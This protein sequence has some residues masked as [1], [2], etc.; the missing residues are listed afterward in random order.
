MK[1]ETIMQPKS[2]TFG[3]YNFS[4]WQI[5]CLVN[6]VDK[7]QPA[8]ST[9]IRWLTA[10]LNEFR[11]HFNLSKDGNLEIE[12]PINE[13]ER[14]H[15]G[16]RVLNEIKKL[17]NQNVYYTYTDEKGEV[18]HRTCHLIQTMDLSDEGDKVIL[19]I[20]VAAL[21]WLIYYGQGVGGTLYD[22][23]SVLAI[24][25]CYAKRVFQ[26][27]SSYL[28]P[29]SWEVSIKKL[30][31]ELS[32][33]NYTVRDFERFVLTPAKKELANNLESRLMFKYCLV[34]KGE[35]KRRGRK[36]LDTVVFKIYDKKSPKDCDNFVND[37]WEEEYIKCL[38]QNKY[39][40]DIQITK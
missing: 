25:G 24:K 8:I 27:L 14:H 37:N 23:N 36:K 26:F 15:H 7:L 11:K 30:M 29:R 9:D 5:N 2:V 39:D 33:P 28:K 16:V 31:Y 17:Y 18:F 20:P 38:K 13:I 12:V 22:K 3:R 19:G 34:S 6:I 1:K 10:D 4:S 21:R 35:Y 40:P 32:A